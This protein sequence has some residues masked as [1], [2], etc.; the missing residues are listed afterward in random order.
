MSDIHGML[1]PFEERLKQL[2]MEDL[3]SGRSK[4]ILLGDYIDRGNDNFAVVIEL[5]RLF[6]LFPGRV[7]LLRGNHDDIIYSFYAYTDPGHNGLLRTFVNKYKDTLS[8]SDIKRI[9][10]LIGDFFAQLPVMLIANDKLYCH[11]F[12]PA[13]WINTNL[14]TNTLQFIAQHRIMD[15]LL[16]Q[17]VFVDYTTSELPNSCKSSINASIRKR[18]V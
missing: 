6:S 16:R 18:C 8:N 4:L 10:Y 12:I 14:K 7:H 15:P 11:G 2:D 3:R 17:A 5:V 13:E 9:Y 1:Q